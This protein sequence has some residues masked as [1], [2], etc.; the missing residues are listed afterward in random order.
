MGRFIGMYR[1]TSCVSA[2]GVTRMNN[3][4]WIAGVLLFPISVFADGFD[5]TYVEGSLLSSEIN[6]GPLDADGDGIGIFGS[7]AIHEDYHI[8]AGYEDQSFDFGIDASTFAIGGGINYVLDEDWDLIGRLSYVNV[9]LGSFAGSRD[10]DGFALMG[11]VRGRLTSKVELDAGINYVDV[12]N[13]DTS[14]FVSGR[15]F[16]NSGLAVGGG[17]GLNDGDATLNITI[18]ALFGNRT[19]SAQR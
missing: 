9:D 6:V 1:C 16:L 3:R 5:Y 19:S 8:F 17:L 15:Y 11:G 4:A 14:L 12:R 10:D 7:Y 18:R 2:S 13:S